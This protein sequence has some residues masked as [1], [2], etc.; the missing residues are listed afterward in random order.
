MPSNARLKSQFPLPTSAGGVS[1]GYIEG[2]VVE[3]LDTLTV[4]VSSGAAYIPGSGTVLDVPSGLAIA[5]PTGMTVNAWYHVYL[6][7]NA[8]SPDL[9]VSATAPSVY[10]GTASTKTGDTSRRYLGSAKAFTSSAFWSFRNTPFCEVS[11]TFVWSTSPFRVL[12]G[13]TSTSTVNIAVTAAVPVTATRAR[14]SGTS[15]GGGS[16][17]VGISVGGSNGNHITWQPSTKF[18][19]MIPLDALQRIAYVW[20]NAPAGAL[21][22][23]DIGGYIYER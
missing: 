21:F 4:T 22:Y 19:E 14:C 15:S 1:V 8:G 16:G 23:I 17:V 3:C 5:A 18:S 7:N 9:E 20:L 2:L 12:S 10:R 6:F 11:Y 13:G